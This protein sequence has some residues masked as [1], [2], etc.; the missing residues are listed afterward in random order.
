MRALLL[1]LLA[2]LTSCQ[3]IKGIGKKKTTQQTQASRPQAQQIGTISLIHPDYGFVLIQTRKGFYL[4]DGTELTCY[5]PA[6]T[7]TGKLKSTAARQGNFITADII[8]G[9]PKKGDLALHEPAGSTKPSLPKPLATNVNPAASTSAPN[10]EPSLP[11]IPVS[12]VTAT[13]SISA[14]P[15]PNTS[16]RVT[17]PAPEQLPD[18][19]PMS[20]TYNDSN[21]RAV[22]SIPL[23]T[24]E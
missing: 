8:S 11:D 7:P 13:P 24:A 18:F 19:E 21:L 16:R 20:Q 4:P 12:S 17:P 23:T 5:S 1:L 10:Q 22:P 6:G 9:S 15:Q 14:S 3:A 2:V